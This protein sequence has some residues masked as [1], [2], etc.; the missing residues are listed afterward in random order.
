MAPTVAKVQGHSRFAHLDDTFR[1]STRPFH[2]EPAVQVLHTRSDAVREW[3]R[4][5]TPRLASIGSAPEIPVSQMRTLKLLLAI[6]MVLLMPIEQAHCAWKAMQTQGAPAAV[7]L[8]THHACCEQQGG[9]R[10]AP[11]PQ[12]PQG[13]MCDFLPVVTLPTLPAAATA[14]PATA[15][16]ATLPTVLEVLPAAVAAAGAPAPEIGSPPLPDRPAA[17]GLRA[18]PLAG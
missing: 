10:P 15:V 17:R 3:G 14:A 2:D 13:C 8:A 5:T 1:P 16:V 4:A 11:R 7:A 9:A 6:P 12:A 18:P